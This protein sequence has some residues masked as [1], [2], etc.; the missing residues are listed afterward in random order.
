M[1]FSLTIE[2]DGKIVVAAPLRCTA[3]AP[4][5]RGPR[6]RCGRRRRPRAR[7]GRCSHVDASSL[8]PKQ[9]KSSHTRVEAGKAKSQKPFRTI[10]QRGRLAALKK[11]RRALLCKRSNHLSSANVTVQKWQIRI[12]RGCKR[13]LPGLAWLLL[14]KHAYLIYHTCTKENL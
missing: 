4:G 14:S 12:V 11:E 2:P 13:F 8:P 6:R 3:A 9:V 5:P 7:G 1:K 10:L